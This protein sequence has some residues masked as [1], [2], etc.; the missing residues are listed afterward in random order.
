MYLCCLIQKKK[1]FNVANDKLANLKE[2]NANKLN[3]TDL[4]RKKPYKYADNI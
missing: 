4:K 1:S 3:C 2:I